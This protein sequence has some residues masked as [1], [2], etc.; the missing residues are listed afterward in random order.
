MNTIIINREKITSAEIEN[1]KNFQSL[2]RNQSLVPAK[3]PV[4]MFWKI[5]GISS[6]TGVIIATLSWFLF[7]HKANK[8]ELMT[9]AGINND[10]ICTPLPGCNVPYRSILY[11]NTS[12]ST[13]QISS[14]SKIEIK[15]NSLVDSSGRIVNGP[16]QIR[17]RQF[18]DPVE[19][20]LSG[21]PME[22]DSAGVKSTFE[23][24][25]MIEITAF[26]Q[27]NPVFILP[28]KPINVSFVSK[29]IENDYN[30]YYLDKV[31]KKWIYKGKEKMVMQNK[32]QHLEKL[33]TN[34]RMSIAENSVRILKDSLMIIQS[35]IADFQ[36]QKPELP[37]Q[38]SPEKW[39]ISLDILRKEFPELAGYEKTIFE[40]DEKF[41]PLNPLHPSVEWNDIKIE[42]AEKPLH[43]YMSFF[44][45]TMTCKYLVYP[46]L[47]GKN[48]MQEV[49]K[50]EQQ[51][52]VYQREL[53]KR[54]KME[55]RIKQKM[56]LEEAN[57]KRDSITFAGNYNS[58]QT[59]QLVTRSFEAIN[60]GI[61]NCDK[62]A[63][64][65]NSRI[66]NPV[67]V[68]NDTIYSKTVI[69]LDNSRNF[70]Q[71]I[72]SGNEMRFDRKSK[73]MLLMVTGNNQIAIF[74]NE[75]FKKIPAFAHD[76]VFHFIPIKTPISSSENLLKVLY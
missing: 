32:L 2:L 30:L 68:V 61:W 38:A 55:D 42:K 21:I 54:K 29:K 33:T 73:N 40:I 27:N 67:F 8:P 13:I 71:K 6:V 14:T 76:Y 34:S 11:Y 20:F 45:D 31:N 35:S 12:D 39:H 59:D 10:F 65:M 46:V 5:F 37:A 3:A 26:F 7:I 69:L 22:Y 51:F 74:K 60:F 41:K 57:I 15:Q 17:F 64:S 44:K 70:I 9:Q 28:E 24:A 19:I 62:P 49:Q 16:I 63:T 18:M 52:S 23:S 25:G 48:Y 53:S 72:T 1:L 4:K 66:V 75:D 36:L 56:I 58:Q 50:S 47:T 43:Y